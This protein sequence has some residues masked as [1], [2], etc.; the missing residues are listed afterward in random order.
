MERERGQQVFRNGEENRVYQ[1]SSEN[2]KRR[3]DSAER[4]KPR[5]WRIFRSWK[6]SAAS[7]AT[8]RLSKERSD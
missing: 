4:W 3:L 7:N 2:S 8:E 5:P 1:R 6:C